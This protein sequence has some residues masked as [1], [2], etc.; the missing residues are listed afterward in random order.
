MAG[1]GEYHFVQANYNGERLSKFCQGQDMLMV[2]THY[3]K[4][5]P[6]CWNALGGREVDATSQGY[7]LFRLSKRGP[8]LSAHPSPTPT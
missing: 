7:T 8:T 5:E 6:T 1:C 3:P 2:D 4:G